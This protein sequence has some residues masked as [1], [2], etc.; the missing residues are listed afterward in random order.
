MAVIS[1][2]KK[3]RAPIQVAQ[4]ANLMKSLLD[5]GIPVASSCHSDGVCAKCRVQVTSGMNYL[6]GVNDI[7]KFLQEK[8]QLK[9]GL[10]I[11]CQTEVNGDVE[12]DTTYW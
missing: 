7:E 1:F 10:R 5:A 11:S 4:G 8:Y 12:I 6:S 9:S 2:T 3:N